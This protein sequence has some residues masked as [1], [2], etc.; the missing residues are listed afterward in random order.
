MDTIFTNS[1]NNKTFEPYRLL[2]N[3]ADKINLKSSDKYVALLNVSIYCTWKNI[4]KSN[5]INR[6]KISV[7]TWNQ[8]FELPDGL[9]FP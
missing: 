4:K 5:K 2:L 3:L 9:Y 1:G 6:F 7:S 8:K